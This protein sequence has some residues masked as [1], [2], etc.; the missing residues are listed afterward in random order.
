MKPYQANFYN[1]I[2]LTVLGV[3][4]YLSTQAPT[5]LIPTIAGLLLLALTP[6]FKKGNRVLAHVAVVITLLIL[7][8]L[9][10]PLKSQL[11]NGDTLGIARVAMMMISSFAAM[12]V[13]IKSFIDARREVR[14]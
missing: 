1:G 10:K 11:E 6:S 14:K 7:I 13:F 3:F 9:F 2:V 12:I 5:A 8:A 4:A